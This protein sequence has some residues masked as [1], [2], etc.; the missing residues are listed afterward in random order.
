LGIDLYDRETS[1]LT[2]KPRRHVARIDASPLHDLIPLYKHPT[3]T[4]ED[5][6]ERTQ[7]CELA[8]QAGS[9]YKKIAE[10]DCDQMADIQIRCDVL[11]AHQ[12][13]I[14]HRMHIDRS[15]QG[16][17]IRRQNVAHVIRDGVWHVQTFPT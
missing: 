12:E 6:W 2:R 4:S 10:A 16:F 17:S 9:G 11:N 5:D 3:K 1:W 14:F 7:R 8:K 13:A 15:R